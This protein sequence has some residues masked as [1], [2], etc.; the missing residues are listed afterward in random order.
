MTVNFAGQIGSN[1]FDFNAVPDLQPKVVI[2]ILRKQVLPEENILRD[3]IPTV[4]VAY[5]LFQAM[6]DDRIDLNQTPEVDMNADDPLVG[7]QF[8]WVTDQVHE[9]RQ[10]AKINAEVG[11]QL[12]NPEGSA[13]RYAG[14]AELSRLMRNIMVAIDNRREFNRATAIVNA[15]KFDPSRT[16]DLTINNVATIS[17]PDQKWDNLERDSFGNQKVNPFVQISQY[18]NRLAFLSGRNPNALLLTGD[19]ASAIESFD[20]FAL[21]R[22]PATLA[23]AR[24][25]IRGLNVFVSQGRKNT[26][27]LDQPVLR[28]IFDNTAIITTLNDE[29]VIAERQYDINRTDQF[30]TAD[31]LFYYVRFWH[32]SKVHVGRP[33]QFFFIKEVLATPYSFNNVS[34]LFY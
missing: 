33:I 12:L 2:G 28:P 18:A 15:F 34:S 4:P 17:D 21:E 26:G 5:K 23:G 27:T 19:I 16:A 25:A 8:R 24:Y 32:K 14:Q 11:R 31:R 7:D 30:I 13:S 10:A 1:N 6:I 29:E 3:I 22:Q 9:Y 20:R